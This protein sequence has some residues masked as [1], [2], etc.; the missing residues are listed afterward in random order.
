MHLLPLWLQVL[1]GYVVDSLYLA[2]VNQFFSGL[3]SF[4]MFLL[5]W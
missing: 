4:Y 2:K 3:K 5:L 1:F